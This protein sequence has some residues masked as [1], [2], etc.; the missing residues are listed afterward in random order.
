MC[1]TLPNATILFQD[2]ILP[3]K[4]MLDSIAYREN[5][6]SLASE[7]W[8][9]NSCREASLQG[10]PRGPKSMANSDA[11]DAWEQL[12]AASGEASP[13]CC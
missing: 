13:G 7:R 1:L 5:P 2:G 4:Q 6:S 10:G 11:A 12:M 8:G 3:S 9:I